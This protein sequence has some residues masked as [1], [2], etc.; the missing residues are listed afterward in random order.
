MQQTNFLRQSLTSL[1]DVRTGAAGVLYLLDHEK[2]SPATIQKMRS[3]MLDAI[4]PIHQ[5]D[6]E[7]RIKIQETHHKLLELEENITD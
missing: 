6:Q 5:M 1:Q 7:T 2:L 3:M 4:A